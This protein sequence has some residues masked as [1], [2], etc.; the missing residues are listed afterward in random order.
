MTD[1]RTQ[2]HTT[3]RPDYTLEHEP[4]SGDMSRVFMVPVNRQPW[5]C[6]LTNHDK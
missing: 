5:Q 2:L 3:L 4:R 1:L 6:W